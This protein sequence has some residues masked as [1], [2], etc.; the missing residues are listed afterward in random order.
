MKCP[1]CYNT[2][3]KIDDYYCH[4][5]GYQFKNKINN[6]A[7]IFVVMFVLAG[8]F[9]IYF[10]SE[11]ES[12]RDRISSLENENNNIR[13]ENTNRAN[14][15]KARINNLINENNRQK[16]EIEN[17]KTQLPQLYLTRYDNQYLYN[18]CANKYEKA[19][20]YYPEKNIPI[21]VYKQEDGYGLTGMG[22]WIPMYC[23]EKN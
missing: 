22:S 6:W 19:N 3:N 14:D 23:L 7:I 16:N 20:C 18:K 10:Y 13:N 15:D 1:K 12:Q 4:N 17:L 2:E 21:Y 5:C 8:I 11:F 9:A